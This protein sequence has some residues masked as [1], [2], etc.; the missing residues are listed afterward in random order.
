MIIEEDTPKLIKIGER[1]GTVTFSTDYLN[2]P[3]EE[4][5]VTCY[6][7]P[8]GS[9]DLYTGAVVTPEVYTHDNRES[10]QVSALSNAIQVLTGEDRTVCRR[11]ARRW[12]KQLEQTHKVYTQ[13]IL[14]A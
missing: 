2:V 6:M 9:D 3:K 12:F 11:M 10:Y 8:C 14:A 7:R 5:V 13:T 4:L 1:M